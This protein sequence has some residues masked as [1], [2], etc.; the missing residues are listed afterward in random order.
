[1]SFRWPELVAD[2]RE[3]GRFT[4]ELAVSFRCRYAIDRDGNRMHVQRQ[5]SNLSGDREP[6]GPGFKHRKARCW[7]QPRK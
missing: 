4:D 2:A 3:V 1:M 6:V 5:T 7:P